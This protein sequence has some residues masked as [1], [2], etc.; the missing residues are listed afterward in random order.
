VFVLYPYL[1]KTIQRAWHLLDNDTDY[2]SDEERIS[3]MVL[4]FLAG[5]DTTA[6]SLALTKDAEI[7]R[8][9]REE[10][11]EDHNPTIHPSCDILSKNRLVYNQT[12][13]LD[14]LVL[15]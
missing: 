11:C 5:Y 15:Y 10:L 6:H 12:H 9:L 1:V 8:D 4:F 14:P 13:L 7:Q 2:T 3:D